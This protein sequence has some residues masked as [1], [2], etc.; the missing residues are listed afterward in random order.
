MNS[1]HNNPDKSILD[2]ELERLKDDVNWST[3][4]QR[5]LKSKLLNNL[6][7]ST[8]NR[9]I[10][11]ILS[12]KLKVAI[13]GTCLVSIATILVYFAV[14]DSTNMNNE[15]SGVELITS[16]EVIY[17]YDI[18]T[19]I[20]TKINEIKNSGFELVLP[21]VSISK[22]MILTNIIQ[23][24]VESRVEVTSYYQFDG[25]REFLIQQDIID[26]NL[27]PQYEKRFSDIKSSATESF[28]IQNF[29]AFAVENNNASI[30][31]VLTDNYSYLIY[32]QDLN[33]EKLKLLFNSM[34]LN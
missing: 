13:T 6:E 23:R 19:N 10:W 29:S 17:P 24:T 7:I 21:T 33:V 20:N 16:G 25:N 5:M 4:R 14:Y 30:I 11:G 1:L 18:K 15:E 28:F 2:I 27:K 34:I 8:S 9:K 31:Y 22:D 26:P 12:A 32:S 3:S